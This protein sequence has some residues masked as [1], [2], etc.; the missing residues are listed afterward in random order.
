MNKDLQAASA[1]V[2]QSETSLVRGR[3]SA[4]A[5]AAVSILFT[6]VYNFAFF[7]NTLDQY[8]LNGD[9][10]AFLL[11]LVVLLTS[12][13]ALVFGLILTKWTL[14]PVLMLIFPLAAGASYFMNN[15][16][17]VIDSVMIQNV[18]ATDSRETTDLF[19][20]ELLAYIALLGV[21]PAVAIYKLNLRCHPFRIE[22]VQRMKFIGVLLVLIVANVVLMGGNY[23]S[24]VREHKVLRYYANPLSF[25]YSAG[26]YV[27]EQLAS[28]ASGPR[29]VIGSDARI[30]ASDHTRELLIMVVGEAARADHFSLNGYERETNPQLASQDVVSYSN[31]YSCATSTALSLPC[32]FSQNGSEDFDV[33]EAKR[34]ENLLDVLQHAGVNVLWRDNNSDS[35]GVAA[36]TEFQDFRSADVNPVCDAE[37][38]DVGMLSGLDDYIVSKP[39]GD[40]VIVLHQMGNHGPAY[41]KRYP[42]EY[43]VFTPVC[44]TNQLEACSQQEIIN[45]YDNAVLYTD[46]FLASVIE[47]LKPYDDEFSTAMFYMA[48]HGES[49]GEHGIYLHGLPYMIAPDSQK[50]VASVMWFGESFAQINKEGLRAREGASFSHDNYFNTVLGML[51]VESTVYD[52]SK[53]ILHVSNG[54]SGLA[55]R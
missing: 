54:V 22:L 46:H 53:D 40:I 16:N 19:S 43:E 24:F 55:A 13:T 26:R 37:C 50:H 45:A 17:I 15:Y 34:Q 1:N 9:N 10:A 33:T 44:E 11:S 14:K 51:E 32:M 48:D 31:V 38:R 23:A 6:L 47:F 41:F 7:R 42:Q 30:A 28:A 36:G 39:N 3:S 27:D 2:A 5:I 29:E 52:S 8:P 35:K 12:V 49:L 21:L 20:I 4:L 18:L 25:M